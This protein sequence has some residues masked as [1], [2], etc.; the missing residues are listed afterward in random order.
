MNRGVGG[1]RLFATDGEFALFLELLAQAR[2]QFEFFVHAYCLMPNHFHFLIE[3]CEDLLSDFIGEVEERYAR[4][5]NRTRERMGHV[6]Q[7]RFKALDC[8]DPSYYRNVL[9]YIENN[10]VKGGLAATCGQW[11]WTGWKQ[12][13]APAPYSLLD[14]DR[15]LQAFGGTFEDYRAWVVSPST[16]D[17][18]VAMRT[19][20]TQAERMLYN[21]WAGAELRS[22]LTELRI[23]VAGSTSVDRV[24]SD[25][26]L[27][28]AFCSEAS[29]LGF[30][31]AEL[32]RFLGCSRP[33]VS[34]AVANAG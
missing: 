14:R 31:N 27:R 32:A 22:V 1:M 7:G 5:F 26:G 16:T 2:K 10:P 9:R 29:G 17:C 28:A 30:S 11:P 6:F 18:L 24:T 15:M 23:K 20:P 4:Y 33:A 3:V 12:A 21:G 8:S 34:R 25:P 19:F 13:A